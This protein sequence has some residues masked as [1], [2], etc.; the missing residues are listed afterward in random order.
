[1]RRVRT[2]VGVVVAALLLGGCTLVPTASSPQVVPNSKIPYGLLD[3]TI[4]GTN[5]ASVQFITQPVW[6]VDATGHLD[7]ASRIVPVP[8]ALTTVLR[9]LILG[10][11][12][13]ER[14]A[15]YVSALPTDLVL[16]SASI[17]GG[18]AY[19]NLATSLS[20]LSKARQIL[21]VGQLVFT[22]KDMGATNGVKI[23]EAG[24]VQELL[25]PNGSH[26]TVATPADFER[27]L[28]H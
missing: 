8:P 10:P 15:G 5:G 9:Q 7:P 28:N 2:L 1:M 25:L 13:I 20:H 21:A 12:T 19:I 27:L 22:S 24:H 14:A 17:H 3:P 26:A 4:P 11:S 23:L 18:V 16:V 6:I